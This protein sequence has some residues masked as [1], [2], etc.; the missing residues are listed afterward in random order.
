[1]ELLLLLLFFLECNQS[2]SVGGG[3]GG[4]TIVSSGVFRTI[5]SWNVKPSEGRREEVVVVVVDDE[6]NRRPIHGLLQDEDEDAIRMV[7]TVIIV[8]V[9]LAFKKIINYEFFQQK[10]DFLISC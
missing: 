7:Q 2:K 1:M 4:C 3:R 10:D 8:V 9:I 5:K 6:S